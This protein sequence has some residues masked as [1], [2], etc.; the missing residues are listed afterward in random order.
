ML[1]LFS[2]LL[3]I[4]LDFSILELVLVIYVFLGICLL[5]LNNLICWHTVFKIFYPIRV[6]ASEA[7][8]FGRRPFI[9]R[10][11]V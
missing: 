10:L 1:K 5:H 7:Q 2:L 8:L 4:Y 9:E 3:K 11:L 6:L